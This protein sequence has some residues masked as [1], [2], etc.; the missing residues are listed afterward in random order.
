MSYISHKKIHS[1]NIL[2]VVTPEVLSK[3]RRE[4]FCTIVPNIYLPNNDDFEAFCFAT[5]E[6]GID[7]S[8][9]LASDYQGISDALRDGLLGY[10]SSPSNTESWRKTIDS[11]LK[12]SPTERQL[13]IKERFQ[14][15][16]EELNW[17]LIIEKTK[18]LHLNLLENVNE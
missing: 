3:L 5:I 18:K 14:I 6:A 11:V 10:L 16:Y 1:L 8:I 17:E 15:V 12:I 4:S 13:V 2:E 9:V 7:S